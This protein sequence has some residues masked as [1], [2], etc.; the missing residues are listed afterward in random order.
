MIAVLSDGRRQILSILLPGDIV[1]TTLLFE[2]VLR[3][4]PEIARLCARQS[5]GSQRLRQ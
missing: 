1:S 4:L 5:P 2:T 3:L